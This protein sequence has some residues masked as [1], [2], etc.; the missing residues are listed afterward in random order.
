MLIA[1]SPFPY[2]AWHSQASQAR[3]DRVAVVM[4]RDRDAPLGHR[5]HAQYDSSVP[6]RIATFC[7]DSVGG[8][9]SVLV[10]DVRDYDFS[11]I[12]K[13]LVANA[14]KDAVEWNHGDLHHHAFIA[15]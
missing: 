13:Q 7:V 1:S 14:W 5:P 10:M 11:P 2:R 6:R 15:M 4:P 12:F 3:K 8:Q 9:Y